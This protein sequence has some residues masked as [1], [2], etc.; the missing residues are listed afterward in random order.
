[1]C[2]NLRAIVSTLQSRSFNNELPQTLAWI[3]VATLNG[4]RYD[5]GKVRILSLRMNDRVWHEFIA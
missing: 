3:H 4:S 5:P 1:M 2:V